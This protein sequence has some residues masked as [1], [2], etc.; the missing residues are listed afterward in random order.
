MVKCSFCG[1]EVLRGTG[2]IFVKKEGAVFRFCSRKCE[3][4]LLLLGRNPV[5]TRW[6]QAFAKA[7]QARASGKK[8]K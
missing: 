1:N 2:K 5:K 3:K 4:N 6:T 8:T 7:K